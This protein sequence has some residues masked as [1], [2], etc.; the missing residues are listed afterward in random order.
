MNAK[1]QIEKGMNTLWKVGDKVLTPFSDG[2]LEDIC[3]VVGVE[4]SSEPFSKNAFAK[5]ETPASPIEWVK[6]KR[7]DG[8]IKEY[9]SW[10]LYSLPEYLKAELEAKEKGA[11]A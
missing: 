3:E 8:T 2:R 5:K 4:G 1:E 10:N 9:A 6:V 7:Q 11:K